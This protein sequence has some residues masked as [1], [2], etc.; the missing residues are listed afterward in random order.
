MRYNSLSELIQVLERASELKRVSHPVKAQLEITEIADRVMKQAAPALLFENVVG[1]NIPLLIHA[2]GSTRFGGLLGRRS[3]DDPCRQ[4]TS[5][6]SNGRFPS[7]PEANR[8][9]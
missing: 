2:F 8:A 7:A 1:K 3:G 6:W 5:I 4:R 9:A